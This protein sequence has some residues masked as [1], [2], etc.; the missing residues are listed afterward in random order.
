MQAPPEELERAPGRG[1]TPTRARA[2]WTAET[3]A[4]LR[5]AVPLAL[6][7]VGQIAITAT[8]TVMM[9]WIGPKA[10]AAG[11]FGSADAGLVGFV[12]TAAPPCS[13]RST[14]ATPQQ[15]V[16]SE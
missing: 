7:Q 16:A 6:T 14:A 13:R 1:P 8:D 2:A 3:R 4:S 15:R 11:H 5:L 12:C 9:G 10:L